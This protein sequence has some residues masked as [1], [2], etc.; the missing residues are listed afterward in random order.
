MAL[1]AI[2]ST[3]ALDPRGA[4]SEP[5]ARL[6][7][8]G[9]RVEHNR[10]ATSIATVECDGPAAGQRTV[11][12]QE[13][14]TCPGGDLRL[15]ALATLHAVMEATRGA[16]RAELIGVKPMRAFDTNLVVVAL[17]AHHEG[18]VTRIV[19]AAI[20][21]DDPLVGTARAALHAI[22]RLAAPLMAR[23]VD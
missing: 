10:G 7:L 3:G 11:G 19:G 22:N 6:L 23:L 20:A 16:L 18:K 21:D 8:I 17:L 14:T 1:P 12:R 13:G 5:S 15:A 9:C 4:S 2:F